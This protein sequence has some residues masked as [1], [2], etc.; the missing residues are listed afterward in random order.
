MAV[1]AGGHLANTGGAAACDSVLCWYSMV[2]QAQGQGWCIKAGV[3]VSCRG[4]LTMPGKVMWLVMFVVCLAGLVSC[5][6]LLISLWT[7]PPQIVRCQLL[8]VLLCCQHCD[9]VYKTSQQCHPL[10]GL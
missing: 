9:T 7:S 3:G 4:G 2:A 6:G 5:C 10:A 1:Y 8:P